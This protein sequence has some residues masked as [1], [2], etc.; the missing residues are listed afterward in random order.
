MTEV[1]QRDEKVRVM[2]TDDEKDGAIEISLVE[3]SKMSCELLKRAL[4]D[5][6]YNIRVW[7]TATHE[8]NAIE[9]ILK[10][11][12]DLALICSSQNGGALSGFEILRKLHMT[13]KTLRAVMLLDSADNN[14]VLEAFRSGA[15]GV[16]ARNDSFEALCKCICCVHRG[17]IWA[18][19]EQLEFVLS[20]LYTA[21]PR[22][23]VNANGG[24]LLT[25]REEEIVHCVANGLRNHE[26]AQQLHLSEHTVKNH[27]F[28]IFDKLGVSSR[29]ELILYVL[30]QRH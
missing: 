18:S 13:N 7:A 14:L 5:S 3:N 30:N 25:V 19:S 12:P 16:C 29:G 21:L 23:L 15:K 26:I 22:S 24:S 4:E 2:R 9:R 20:E 8:H 27:M 28:R 10:D 11:G 17:Q 6:P 1:G